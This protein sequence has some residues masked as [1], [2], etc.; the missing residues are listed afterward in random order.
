VA[1]VGAANPDAKRA[2][3]T[4]FDEL[5]A[6]ALFRAVGDV[7]PEH[8]VELREGSGRCEPNDD[9]AADD[10]GVEF[11]PGVST[12]A[13]SSLVGGSP[14]NSSTVIFIGQAPRGPA[15]VPSL[16]PPAVARGGI[17]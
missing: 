14:S 3:L 11:V 17:G 6:V 5:P 8:V 12:V 7:V 1:A 4:L 13:N 10:V 2:H 15:V 9:V 16:F